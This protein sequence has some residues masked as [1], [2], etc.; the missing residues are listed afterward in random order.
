MKLF[1]AQLV[2][3][4]SCWPDLWLCFVRTEHL[5]YQKCDAESFPQYQAPLGCWWCLKSV[6]WDRRNWD[7]APQETCVTA[8]AS[9]S[10]LHD[11]LK[12]K[13]ALH[14]KCAGL[15]WRCGWEIQSMNGAPVGQ[16]PGS[17]EGTQRGGTVLKCTGPGSLPSADSTCGWIHSQPLLPLLESKEVGWEKSKYVRVGF[18]VG[19]LIHRRLLT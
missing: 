15:G 18:L 14:M 17:V 5:S 7:Y 16:S 10:P 3:R 12:S 11:R 9:P 8:R 1:F 6:K 19:L 2:F 13:M 4:T